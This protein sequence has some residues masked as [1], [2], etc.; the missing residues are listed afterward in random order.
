MTPVAETLER[1]RSA[2][3]SESRYVESYL[4]AYRTL[5]AELD[6]LGGES[7][8]A[9]LGSRVVDRTRADGQLPEPSSVRMYARTLCAER[10]IPIP[11]DSPLQENE[12][13][14]VSVEITEDTEPSNESGDG[15]E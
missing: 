6:A 10:G 8:V 2:A 9:E 4:P 13:P 7:A 15:G 3:P 5:L 11:D 14:G 1:V 12:A